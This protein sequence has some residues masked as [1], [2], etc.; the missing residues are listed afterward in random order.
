MSLQPIYISGEMMGLNTRIKPFLLNDRAFQRLE[1]AYCFRERIKKRE[2]I[3]LLGRLRRVLTAQSLSNTVVSNVYNNGGV[4]IY[5]TL[6]ITE[7]NAEIEPGSVT[8]SIDGGTTVLTDSTLDGILTPG[9]NAL[10]ATGGYINY[11]TGIF[12]ISF[13]GVIGAFPVTINFNYFPSLPVM[14][15]WERDIALI[16][17]EQTVFFDTKYA[18]VFSSGG[19]QELAAGTTWTGDDA[20]FF[21]AANYRGLDD[22]LRYF[23][24]TNFNNAGGDPIRYYNGATWAN[25]TPLVSALFTLYQAQIIVPY[26]G[27]LI[28]L[29]TWEGTTA[30]TFASASNFFNRC[31]FSQIGDPTAADAWRTDIFGKGGFIDAPTNEQIISCAFFKNT[32]IVFFESS[33]WQLRYVGEYGL[34]FI[35]ERINSELGSESTYSTIVFDGGILGVGDKGII[36]ASSTGVTRIDENI[37]DLVFDVI[38]NSEDGVIRVQGVRE[39]KKELAYWSYTDANYQ[40]KFPN[41][42]LVYN[43]INGTFSIFRDNVTAFGTFRTL[44]GITWDSLT[45]FWYDDEVFW[46]A[47]DGQG[48]FPYVVCGN[49][50]GY[51][52]LYGYTTIN[53]YSLSVTGI[54]RAVSPLQLTIINHNFETGDIIYLQDMNFV[55]TTTNLVVSTDLND[56]IYQVTYVDADTVSLSKWD[57]DNYDAAFSYTPAN[58]TGTYIGGG[59]VTLLPNMYIQT[60]D[61][62]PFSQGGGQIKLSYIDFL[63]DATANASVAVTVFCNSSPAVIGNLLVGNKEVETYATQ[64]YVPSSQYMWHRFFALCSGNY[65][66]ILLTYDDDQM[67]TLSIHQQTMTLNA[68]ALYVRTGGRSI[69]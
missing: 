51:I 18:Y 64:F 17:T 23:F 54:N 50:Q 9:L 35:W 31:R 47:T 4:S 32:L 46:D 55:N 37:P 25:L 3:K 15:I 13:A 45:T 36:T 5:T 49:Q 16:N 6:S 24:V 61:F 56:A 10:G 21:W 27:R 42:V 1:N 57:G 52:H 60:K 39:F 2:G 26:Y 8:I 65:L 44:D 59:K 29:N 38:N 28:M 22:S 69:F 43:Y 41:R 33:T 68:M 30:G 14:G 58:G 40:G 7:T 20:D 67:N 19:F 11:D 62:N 12:S 48:S 53:D 63:T 66:N 34:P